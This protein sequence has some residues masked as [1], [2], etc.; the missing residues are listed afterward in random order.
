MQAI[1]LASG[2]K[3]HRIVGSGRQVPFGFDRVADANRQRHRHGDAY[4]TVL[5]SGV[6]EQ[7]GYFGRYRVEAGD[8]LVQPTLDYHA[9]CMLT[10]GIEMVRLPWRFDPGRGGVYRGCDVEAVRRTAERDVAEAAALLEREIDRAV[11]LAP[12]LERECDALALHMA[13]EG[14]VSISDWSREICASR[15]WVSRHFHQ[16]FGVGPG[17]FRTEL[18]ARMAWLACMATDDPLAAI[19]VA[20]NHSDQSHMTRSI[21]WLTGETPAA[22][23]RS[24]RQTPGR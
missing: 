6:L 13:T 8:V 11:L 2:E 19:A 14:A 4:A 1:S 15:E 18:K 20:T 22:W 17:R 5:L 21:Q 3:F 7:A 24:A 10:H 12:L 9:D 16:T 23:R